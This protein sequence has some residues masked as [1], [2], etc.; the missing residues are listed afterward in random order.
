[1]LEGSK[2]LCRNGFCKHPP[3]LLK[4]VENKTTNTT[5]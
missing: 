5:Q 1:M 3:I 4:I 2:A